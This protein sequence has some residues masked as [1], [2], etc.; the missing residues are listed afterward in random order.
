MPGQG[1]DIASL[2]SF[3]PP[4]YLCDKC[5]AL[6]ATSPVDWDK[7]EAVCPVCRVKYLPTEAYQYYNVDDYL[8]TKSLAPASL[9]I[10]PCWQPT[11]RPCPCHAYLL[12]R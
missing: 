6:L 5:L 11:Q 1:F 3:N 7:V 2:M 8:K 12:R 9:P 4:Q 10:Q